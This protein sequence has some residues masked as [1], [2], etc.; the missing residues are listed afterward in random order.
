MIPKLFQIGPIAIYSYGLMM[1]VAFII[2]NILLTRELIRKKMDGGAGATITLLA[3]FGGL[4]GAKLFYLIENTD[5][6]Q[7]GIIR[8]IFS[9]AGLTFY[10]GLIVA[11]IF[12]YIYVRRK[13]YSFLQI[14]DA[15]APALILAYGIG[16]IGCQLAGDGDYGIPTKLPWGMTYAKGTAKPTVELEEYFQRNPGEDSV[17]HYS[18]Y[19][20]ILTGHDDF[21]P[22]TK[23]DE[24]THLHPAPLYEFIYSVIIFAFLWMKRKAW[25]YDVGRLFGMYLIIQGLA[26][27]IVEFLR[28]N[29]LYFSLSMAQWIGLAAAAFG[30]VLMLRAKR[31]P[32]PET[33]H[34]QLLTKMPC[35]LC[36]VMKSVIDPLRAKLDFDYEEIRIHD[37]DE[38]WESYQDKVPVLLASGKLIAKY[39][40]TEEELQTRI[41]AIRAAQIVR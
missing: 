2:G 6:F 9:P 14:A 38:W 18:E 25:D 16:R 32:A 13:K 5:E 31:I 40:I 28:L 1:G 36:D 7:R 23:F 30:A 22:I 12:I 4:L 20:M 21:G 11:I 33:I 39:S 27:F 19:R 24:T 35:E 26:R 41:G 34:L 17:Y 37:G 29:P 3:L 15:V 10:G 8:A